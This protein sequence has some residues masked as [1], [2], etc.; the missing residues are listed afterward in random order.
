MDAGVAADAQAAKVCL[1]V[2]S[3]LRTEDDVVN[4][5]VDGYAAKATLIPTQLEDSQ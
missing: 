2:V 4:M 3:G 1:D 5:E